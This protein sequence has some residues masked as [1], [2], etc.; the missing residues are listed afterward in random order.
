MMPWPQWAYKLP[1]TLIALVA[2]ALAFG[3]L[4]DTRH[5]TTLEKVLADVG[6][7]L[8]CAIIAHAME[9]KQ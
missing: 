8:V 3:A 1:Q 2:L 5:G 6:A 7:A 9:P 4:L